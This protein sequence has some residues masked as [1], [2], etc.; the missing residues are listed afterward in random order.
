MLRKR[1]PGIAVL[2]GVLGFG[3]AL[4]IA[5]GPDFAA[6]LLCLGYTALF[7]VGLMWAIQPL[8]AALLSRSAFPRTLILTPLVYCALVLLFLLFEWAINQ[9]HPYGRDWIAAQLCPMLDDGDVQHLV[10]ATVL[11][12]FLDAF[13]YRLIG[14]E[15]V[16]DCRYYPT[17]RG[18]RHAVSRW[19][20]RLALAG[21]CILLVA[22]DAPMAIDVWYN[23]T[24]YRS[25]WQWPPPRVF[26]ACLVGW[27]VAWIAD[28]LARPQRR[29]LYVAIGFLLY[30]I[31]GVSIR[32]A[33]LRE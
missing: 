14:R 12:A 30:A 33:V 18:L 21:G 26:V 3:V 6:E 17:L 28:A 10:L 23:A 7:L 9:P 20:G 1:L 5:T 15:K 13:V 4:V 29:T 25:G 16:R 32:T 31:L 27:G 24:F 2:I 19:E 11:L 22:N 8:D